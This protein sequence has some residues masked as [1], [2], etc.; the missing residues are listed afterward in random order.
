M[1][2]IAKQCIPRKKI[3]N[4][5]SFAVS[6]FHRAWHKNVITTINGKGKKINIIRCLNLNP[7]VSG[8]Y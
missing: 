5:P 1:C 8:K 6:S 7:F 3:N 4:N 2:R